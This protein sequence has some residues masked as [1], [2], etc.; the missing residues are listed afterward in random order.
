VHLSPLT[1]ISL[2]VLHLTGCTKVV[3]LTPLEGMKLEVISLPPMVTKGLDVLRNMSSL[4]NIDT[5]PP[6]QF[7]REQELK[8]AGG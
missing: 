5:K 4:K 7:W 2:T 6:A 1:G 8:K 3:D